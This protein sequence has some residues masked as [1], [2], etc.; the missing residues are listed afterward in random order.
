MIHPWHDVIPGVKG[1]ELPHYFRAVIEIPKG[2][3]NKYELDKQTG[4][5]R[6]DRVLSSAVY[7][8][9]NYGFI[10]QTL[11]E[12]HDPLDVLVFCTE[13]IPTLTLCDAR[14]IGVMTMIDGGEPDHKIVAVLTNDPEFADYHKASDFPK[15]TF[16]ML[17]RFFEDY[18]QLEG[19][20]VE[21]DEIM[22]AEAAEAIIDDCLRRYHHARRAGQISPPTR[23]PRAPPP[24]PPPP[25]PPGLP[26][27][28][29]STLRH[30]PCVRTRMDY[31]MQ[32][33]SSAVLG[34]MYRQDVA[35]N[36]LANLNTAGFKPD[37]AQFRQRAPARIEDS[38]FLPSDRLL[39][40]LGA[41][42][43]PAPSRIRFSQGTML[44][45]G[46][47]L[48]AAIEG[49]GFF[50]VRAATDGRSD[51]L[52]LTR[53]GRFALD[54]NSRLVLASSGLPVLDTANRTVTLPP[55]APVSIDADGR[56]LRDG[57]VLAQLNLVDVPDRRQLK[58]EGES[59]F[60]PSASAAGNLRPATGRIMQGSVEGSAVNEIRAMMEVQSASR[61]VSSS[62]GILTYQDRLLDQ[63]INTFGRTA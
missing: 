37:V 1:L 10:P 26:P 49:E 34:N 25:P 13:K 56:I 23:L 14:A 60:A 4:L 30:A 53:D 6:L 8:P 18:K 3:S 22:P 20:A 52:M 11:A 19:K 27:T 28:R 12:D 54:S 55:G 63:A 59:L 29:P 35:A 15:H 9:A 46:N 45:T 24:P 47:D 50:L 48:D 36:N 61:A 62:I 51:Q 41:G 57:A 40:S 31:G 32:I 16:K 7:Y 33:A 21:V 5:L 58:K 2:S 17:K 44:S 43:T 38:L 39:E 42:I